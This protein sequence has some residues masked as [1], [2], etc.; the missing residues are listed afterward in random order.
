MLN[1]PAKMEQEQTWILCVRYEN[2]VVDGIANVS[3]TGSIAELKETQQNKMLFA[4]PNNNIKTLASDTGN[5]YDY[6]FQ[7]TKEFDATLHT[8]DGDLDISLSGNETFPYDT[9]K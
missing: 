1:G 6:S 3:L 8:S 2:A 7:Y 4:I 9:S 5:T